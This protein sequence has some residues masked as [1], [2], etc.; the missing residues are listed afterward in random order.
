LNVDPS[1]VENVLYL[2]AKG[3]TPKAAA[4]KGPNDAIGFMAVMGTSF[5]RGCVSGIPMRAFLF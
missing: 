1:P 4:D 5:P 2:A 3:G